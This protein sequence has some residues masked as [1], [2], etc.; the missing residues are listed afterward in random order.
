MKTFLTTLL[1]VALFFPLR[2]DEYFTKGDFTNGAEGWT[3]NFKIGTA[4]AGATTPPGALVIQLQ[5]HEW[6]WLAQEINPK[7]QRMQ[8]EIHYELSEDA[9][10]ST[11]INEYKALGAALGEPDRR[12]NLPRTGVGMVLETNVN[13]KDR[14][15]LP[16]ILKTGT[17]RQETVYGTRWA[18]EV[19]Q[20]E[21]ETET[22]TVA[23]PPGTGTVTL[24]KISGKGKDPSE[25]NTRGT[26]SPPTPAGPPKDDYIQNSDFSQGT[27]NWGGNFQV[28]PPPAVPPQP[29]TPPVSKSSDVPDGGLVIQLKPHE[30][31]TLTQDIVV[32]GY[33][34]QLKT[35]CYFDRHATFSTDPKDYENAAQK[36]GM[37]DWSNAVKITTSQY[38]DKIKGRGY[39]MLFGQDKSEEEFFSYGPDWGYDRSQTAT[40]PF[41]FGMKDNKR[42]VLVALPPGTGTVTIT[43]ITGTGADTDANLELARNPWALGNYAVD[44]IPAAPD[45]DLIK[46]GDFNDGLTGWKGDLKPYTSMTSTDGATLPAPPPPQTGAY[47]ELKKS[48]WVKFSQGVNV[49]SPWVR[50]SVIYAYSSNVAFS[51]LPG[52]YEN[53]F[54][55]VD[56]SGTESGK[57]GSGSYFIED[58][59]THKATYSMFWPQRRGTSTRIDTTFLP[60]P[61]PGK[62][63]VNIFL[64]LPPGKGI[65]VIYRVVV[66]PAQDSRDGH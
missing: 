15:T 39:L 42:T 47:F 43:K 7:H 60:V 61:D 12:I 24:S 66:Q 64:G 17:R 45:D 19:F 18:L 62:S 1:V 34:M 57:Q 56:L 48:S 32:K 52:D 2:A 10:L 40:Y 31:T 41:R 8:F 5:P 37:P 13:Q 53:M 23:L 27:A 38:G 29:A 21:G 65:I 59:D 49:T 55:S 63:R 50:V 28:A 35:V 22:V 58:A 20:Q 11:D 6:S 44:Q 3:G 4:P 54:A 14:T 36:I 16:F 33:Q 30:W 26:P 25:P 9:V 46:N 51:E